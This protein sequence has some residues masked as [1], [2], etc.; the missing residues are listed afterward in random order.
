MH[1]FD[2]AVYKSTGEALFA[3]EIS[4]IQLNLGLKCNMS[5]RHCHLEAGP[6]RAEMMEDET[7]DAVLALS[8]EREGILF[9][10]TGGAPE[11]HPRLMEI[12]KALKDRGHRVQVR[13]N[14]TILTNTEHL[15]LIDFYKA[16]EVN[17]VAS[18]PC[19]LETNIT[20]QRGE[21]AYDASIKALNLL[22]EA[23]Y[24]EKL[25]LN[26]VFNPGGPFLPPAQSDLENAYRKELFER[27]GINFT[28]L[29]TITN[30]PIGRFMEELDAVGEAESYKK[31]LSD[32]FNPRTLDGLMCRRQICIN[33]DGTIRDCDFNHALSIPTAGMAPKNIREFDWSALEGR[34]IATGNHCFGCTA[35]SGS[36]CAGALD[37][38]EAESIPLAI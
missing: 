6:H 3:G 34:K 30:M 8:S 32:S 18:L 4:T 24:G 2:S 35:G 10:I 27:F 11:L 13:T 33:W 31:L 12:I 17:L 37:S 36:S 19:Y 28:S 38:G 21:G 20:A 25:P 29:L 5:C 7:V 1:A 16:N 9:D 14:L 15:H 23:G 22:N 26:L